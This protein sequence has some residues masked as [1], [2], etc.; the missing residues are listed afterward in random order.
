M[1]EKIFVKGA[2]IKVNKSTYGDI[3]KLAIN[4][5][6]FMFFLEQNVK[7]NGWVDIDILDKRDGSGK[8]MV[9]DNYK[10]QTERQA[11]GEV[12]YSRGV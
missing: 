12:E 8:Y 1:E 6:L 10:P 2:N 4:V 7:S 9:L 5:P 3:I 11:F